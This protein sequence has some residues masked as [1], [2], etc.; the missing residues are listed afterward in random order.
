MAKQ[1]TD[2]SGSSQEVKGVS[3]DK[4]G[5][6]RDFKGSQVEGL[7]AALSRCVEESSRRTRRA[8]CLLIR[9]DHVIL[10][11]SWAELTRWRPTRKCG[12]NN[13]CQAF[14]AGVCGSLT[15][16]FIQQPE[17]A[18]ERQCQ[19]RRRNHREPFNAG[20]GDFSA[21]ALA[22]RYAASDLRNQRTSCPDSDN[23]KGLGRILT[24]LPFPESTAVGNPA[25]RADSTELGR[26]R[27][28]R[29]SCSNDWQ[30]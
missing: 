18:V 15:S 30:K 6:P 26:H 3:R 11:R 8:H 29:R 23:D 28:H 12:D 27:L 16:H 21:R 5:T 1:L 13:D 14:G 10:A 19:L 9:A 2:T 7:V 17:H 25:H 4:D 24:G 20:C 22:R